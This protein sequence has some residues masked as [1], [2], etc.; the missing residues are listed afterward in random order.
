MP[1]DANERVVDASNPTTLVQFKNLDSNGD[2]FDDSFL[3]DTRFRPM[4]N[5]DATKMVDRYAV[6]VPPSTQKPIAVT[7]TVYYQSVKAIVT[8]KFLGNITDTDE[9]FVLEPCVLN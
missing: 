8:L 4:P 6:V 3:K 5:A 2:L 1:I 9:D 7:T